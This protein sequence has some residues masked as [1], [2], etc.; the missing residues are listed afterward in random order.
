MSAVTVLRPAARGAGVGLTRWS[1]PALLRIIVGASW[2]G[3][4]LLFLAAFHTLAEMRQAVQTIGR[5]TVPSVLA[6]QDIRAALVDM[7]ANAANDLLAGPGGMAAAREAFESRRQTVA[8]RLL[9]AAQNITYGD[10]ER[11]PI[12]VV[13]D[14]VGTYLQRV[15]QAQALQPQDPAAALGVYREATAQMHQALLPAADA[16]DAANASHLETAYRERRA[17]AGQ[18]M[19]LVYLIGGVLIVGLVAA[20]VFLLRRTRR[21]ASP[22]L[23]AATLIALLFL[24]RLGTAFGAEMDHLKVAKQDAFD[25]LHALSQA[26]SI[27]YDANGDESLF[28]LDRERA[29]QYEQAFASK[30]GQIANAPDFDQ[31]VAAAERGAVAFNG[32]LADELR[33]ITFPGERDAALATLRAF[34]QYLAIDREIRALEQSGQHE[35]AVALCVGTAEG[36]SNWAFDR[37]DAALGGT[38]DINQQAFDDAISSGFAD[39]QGLDLLAPGAALAIAVLAWLGIRPRLGEYH[40]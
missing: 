36:Q 28:L 37:F 3:A 9:D 35:A 5:D 15:A 14:G 25:S 19:I 20:Q 12:G 6:A 38:I 31:A 2:V 30:T 11:V 40:V 17:A 21:L 13:A 24:L 8:R 32:F 18:A 23:V 4:L 22:P 26:R 27:A 7:D 33:N 34:G 10:E 39:L 16:L 29:A 1:T